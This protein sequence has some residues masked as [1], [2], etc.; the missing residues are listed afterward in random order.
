MIIVA[1]FIWVAAL[2]ASA[3]AIAWLVTRAHGDRDRIEELIDRADQ[4]LSGT[5]VQKIPP[6]RPRPAPGPAT[7]PAAKVLLDSI[8][9]TGR[10][11]RSE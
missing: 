5:H 6:A 11:A 3:I 4:I 7:M 9:T 10:H 1:Q 2:L 8:Q